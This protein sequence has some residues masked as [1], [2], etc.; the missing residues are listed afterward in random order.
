MEKNRKMML[1]SCR[2]IMENVQQV[3][4]HLA[5]FDERYE[6]HNARMDRRLGQVIEVVNKKRNDFDEFRNFLASSVTQTKTRSLDGLNITSGLNGQPR[7][8]IFQPTWLAKYPLTARIAATFPRH[9][10]GGAS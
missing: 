10:C 3:N 6:S 9:S 2:Q 4:L 5:C 7:V 1:E 8:E